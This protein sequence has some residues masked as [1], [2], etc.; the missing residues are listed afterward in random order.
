MTSLD[1][2]SHNRTSEIISYI[3]HPLQN[4]QKGLRPT[5]SSRSLQN[6]SFWG[7][8]HGWTWLEKI[9]DP[10]V[11]KEF[12]YTSPISDYTVFVPRPSGHA[13]LNDH[14][15]PVIGAASFPKPYCVF[16]DTL[17]NSTLRVCIFERAS[18]WKMDTAVS[19]TFTEVFHA[20]GSSF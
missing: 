12:S 13:N 9:A 15:V 6:L 3:S 5:P 11:K 8:W 10:I 2:S 19:E 4:A 20:H 16:V 17:E 18:A 14:I 7:S 1:Y